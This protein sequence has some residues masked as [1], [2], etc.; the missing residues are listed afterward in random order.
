MSWSTDHVVSGDMFMPPRPCTAQLLSKFPYPKSN[1]RRVSALPGC[2]THR[3]ILGV[4]L[5]VVD[6]VEVDDVD[7]PHLVLPSLDDHL[8]PQGWR[9]A[10]KSHVFFFLAARRWLRA[11]R[12]DG[13]KSFGGQTRRQVQ[14]TGRRLSEA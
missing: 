8:L 13:F 3:I 11:L 12:K 1:I 2:T 7:L 6:V 5:Q 9:G 14:Q 10:A 4:W